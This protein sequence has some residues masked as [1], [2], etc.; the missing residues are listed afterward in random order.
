MLKPQV[1]INEL[2]LD[3]TNIIS[4]SIIHK[5]LNYPNCYE[6]LL[7]LEYFSF[8]NIKK[9]K[10]LN[11]DKCKII[12]FVNY[13]KHTYIENWFKEQF[14]LYSPIFGNSKIHNLEL[15]S[16]G[17]IHIANFKLKFFKQKYFQLQNVIFKCKGIDYSIYLKLESLHLINAIGKL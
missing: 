8:Y 10:N 13:N 6:S 17:K 16:H 2:K 3:S 14:L 1:A 11:C 9:N 12:E 4:P 15:M 5:Y 7:L